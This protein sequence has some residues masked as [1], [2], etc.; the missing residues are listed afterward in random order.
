MKPQ[1][2]FSLP[3][4]AQAKTPYATLVW[5]AVVDIAPAEALGHGPRGER[6][7]VPI[8]GGV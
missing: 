6:W 5:S 7:I 4:A 8:L 3:Q 2:P 1:D